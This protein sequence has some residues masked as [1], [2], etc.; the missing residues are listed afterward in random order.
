MKVRKLKSLKTQV[1]KVRKAKPAKNLIKAANLY[2]LGSDPPL[3]RKVS[4]AKEFVGEI[5]FLAIT[6]FLEVENIIRLFD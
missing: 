4:E 5:V 6:F 3:S 1:P 2:L